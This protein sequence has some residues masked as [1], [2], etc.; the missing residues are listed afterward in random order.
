MA[1]F[2]RNR[3]SFL[4]NTSLKRSKTSIAEDEIAAAVNVLLEDKLDLLPETTTALAAIQYNSAGQVYVQAAAV[5]RPVAAETIDWSFLDEL[6]PDLTD[7][8]QQALPSY[9]NQQQNYIQGND[10]FE[11]ETVQDLDTDDLGLGDLLPGEDLL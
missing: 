10:F 7:A 5:P 11:D 6:L 4:E 1:T 8:G 9:A 3:N 2:G